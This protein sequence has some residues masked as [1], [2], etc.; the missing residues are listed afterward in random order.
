MVVVVMVRMEGE[1]ARLCSVCKHL[2]ETEDYTLQS[3]D[4]FKLV[5]HREGIKYFYDM[6]E[7]HRDYART[8]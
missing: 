8:S 1:G 5:L 4:S 2:E 3:P 6:Y 7:E